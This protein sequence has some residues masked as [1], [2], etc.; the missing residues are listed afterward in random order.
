MG[1]LLIGMRLVLDSVGF[2]GVYWRFWCGYV[3]F[4]I[5]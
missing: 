1:L 2:V 4:E 5:L 3:E